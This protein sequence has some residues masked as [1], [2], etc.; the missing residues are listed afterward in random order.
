MQRNPVRSLTALSRAFPLAGCTMMQASPQKP[1]TSISL[2]TI[3][4][5]LAA[6]HVT[7][8]HTAA[9]FNLNVVGAN[10]STAATA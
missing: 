10:G 6:I 3:R 4:F 1:L 5:D 7:S 8:V 9:V 2:D